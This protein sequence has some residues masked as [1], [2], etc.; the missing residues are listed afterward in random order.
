MENPCRIIV[1][2]GVSLVLVLVVAVIHLEKT[3]F[4]KEALQFDDFIK[5]LDIF[6]KSESIFPKIPQDSTFKSNLE[7]LNSI[8]NTRPPCSNKKLSKFE[9]IYDQNVTDFSHCNHV[10]ELDFPDVTWEGINKVS[11]EK[12]HLK[13]GGYHKPCSTAFST[14]TR[15]SN[16]ILVP[17]RDRENELKH[18]VP[19]MH[20]YLQKTH[21][22][23]T[24]QIF[25]LEQT[26][27]FKFNRA[28]LLNIGY[29]YVKENYPEFTCFTFAD[30]DNI[31][32]TGQCRYYC[33]RINLAYHVATF[34]NKWK[35]QKPKF[36]F[37]FFGSIG[38]VNGQDLE[39]MNGNPNRFYGWGGEDSALLARMVHN[40]M[41]V[42]DAD[43]GCTV[44][45]HRHG[46]D[47]GNPTSGKDF[48]SNHILMEKFGH[49]IAVTD[50]LS[51]L[52][53]NVTHKILKIERFTMLTKVKID[54]LKCV[55]PEVW[56]KRPA[57]DSCSFNET[58][59]RYGK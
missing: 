8:N 11:I 47:D 6:G 18:F 55:V 30:I 56:L 53:E 26:Q 32:E 28:M 7:S 24:Y 49:E 1:V 44:L 51:S 27:N 5:Q 12:L 4:V 43:N 41:S 29:L 25:I 23:L 17:F 52:E 22:D 14:K 58:K 9:G 16:A 42:S 15:H 13:L 59:K 21:P 50:G 31:P 33:P 20:Q 36:P 45:H 37:G 2:L 39:R 34:R 46:Y 40:N 54:F 35:Y 57:Y 48:R 38:I 10:T 19:Y 3:S